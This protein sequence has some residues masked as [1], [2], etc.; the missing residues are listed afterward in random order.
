MS[1]ILIFPAIL[2]LIILLVVV[3]RRASMKKKNLAILEQAAE[4]L[5]EIPIKTQQNI[6]GVKSF[7]DS[8]YVLFY[9]GVTGFKQYDIKKVNSVEIVS[10]RIQGSRT[11]CLFL[12]DAAGETVEKGLNF[13]SQRDAEAMKEFIMKYVTKYSTES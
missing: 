1:Y 12:N 4:K 2:I 10:E 7:I 11:Y 13:A 3:P 9:C 8:N 5:E 6:T